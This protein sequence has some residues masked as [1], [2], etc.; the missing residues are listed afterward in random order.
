M[1]E[2]L[3]MSEAL[4]WVQLEHKVWSREEELEEKLG[5]GTKQKELAKASQ[6]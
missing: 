6:G 3:A 5:E 4:A 1:P 2:S